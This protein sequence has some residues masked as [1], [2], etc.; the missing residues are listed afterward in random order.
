MRC[1]IKYIISIILLSFTGLNLNAQDSLLPLNKSTL[2]EDLQH[3]LAQN[4][5]A[6]II[7]AYIRLAEHMET[8]SQADSA[9]YYYL[10]A[11][12]A[13]G[14]DKKEGFYSI[15]SKLGSLYLVLLDYDN[16]VAQLNEST[17]YYFKKKKYYAYVKNSNLLG[18]A[19]LKKK[20]QVLA[21]RNFLNSIEINNT[22]LKDTVLKIENNSFMIQYLLDQGDNYSALKLANT[23]IKLAEIKKL[24]G[25]LVKNKIYAATSLFSIGK[26]KEANQIL[27]SAER[28]ATA[29]KLTE[30]LPGIYK[31]LSKTSLELGL[32]DSV[33]YF[34]DKYTMSIKEL[35]NMEIV[36]SSKEI[37]EKFN[38]ENKDN[39]IK[40]L[41]SQNAIKTFN[42]QKQQTAIIILFVGLLMLGLLLYFIYRNYTNQI[43]NNEIINEQRT[44]LN[45]QQLKQ[46]QKDNQIIA[47]EF[48]LRGQEDERNR[49]GKDL[50]DS[51]G[52]MLSTIKLHMSTIKPAEGTPANG[53]FEKT[54]NLL[55]DACEEVRKISRDMMPITLENY[56]LDVALG[57][58][59]D[60]F[61]TEAGPQ[62][63]YQAFGRNYILSKDNELF[64]YRMIQELVN[65][66]IKHAEAT[67]ILIQINFLE[68][69]MVITVEDDGKGFYYHPEL[70]KGMGLKNL[71]YRVQYLHG[72][73]SIDTQP[74]HGTTV[75]I[76][77]PA[78]VLQKT[79]EVQVEI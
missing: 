66:S 27:L 24:P 73:M 48:M 54:K 41:E 4:K 39:I 51:L 30:D 16:A 7:D 45:E 53:N 44:K 62:V 70:F 36:R 11:L 35:T 43:K 23:S 32:K 49:I 58:L 60:K 40:Y 20:N 52:A 22:Y 9:V 38:S 34:L 29:N 2:H 19:Y 72:E 1:F 68:T 56:G 46:A 31:L 33:I 5:S 65:N 67:E 78:E 42:Q 8:N 74:N 71:D 28:L 26:F 12:G 37:S 69:K 57:E 77:I 14:N 63:I 18:M 47:M 3:A 61:T 75:V 25:D 6:R 21:R 10:K 13:Y 79:S 50:H 55:D 59:T 15:K 76:E 64:I 17:Q